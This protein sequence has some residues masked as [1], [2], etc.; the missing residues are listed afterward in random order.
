MTTLRAPKTRAFFQ[1][2]IRWVV[3]LAS[4]PLCLQLV[5][6]PLF[7]VGWSLWEALLLFFSY[8][9]LLLPFASFAGGVAVHGHLRS[10]SVIINATLVSVIA[11]ALIAYASP[12]AEYRARVVDGTD[13]EAR[14]PAGPE[15]F[16]GLR[17]LRLAAEANP[18]A[19]FNFAVEHPLDLP[20]NWLTYILHSQMVVALFGI[21]AAL[22][23]QWGGFLTSGL[24]PPARRNARWALGLFSGVA[25]FIAEAACGEWVRLDPSNSGVLGAWVPLLVP[26]VE[27]TFLIFLTRSGRTVRLS[28]ASNG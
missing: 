9:G 27:L 3:I 2:T 11:F 12:I 8:L 22:L 28:R 16:G 1:E 4:V 14:F 6:G 19:D 13:F 20:P 25:F 7:G 23:G 21:L 26:I 24:S 10:R 15:T 18:P 5:G 17:A